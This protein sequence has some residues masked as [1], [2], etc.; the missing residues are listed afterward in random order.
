MYR[1]TVDISGADGADPQWLKEKL[2]TEFE[3]YG[4]VRIA[5]VERVEPEQ[6]KMEETTWK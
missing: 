2:A 3:K 1:I 5:K 4:N 6:M